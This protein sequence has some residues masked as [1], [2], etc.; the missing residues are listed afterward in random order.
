MV[1][2]EKLEEGMTKQYETIK[3]KGGIDNIEFLSE[4]IQEDVANFKVKLTYGDGSTKEEKVKLV[5]EEGDWKLGI[6]K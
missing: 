3:E 2:T 5:K 4:D 6:S 1:D